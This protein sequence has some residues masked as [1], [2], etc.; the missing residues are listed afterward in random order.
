MI[1]IVLSSYFS[2]HCKDECLIRSRKYPV[3]PSW[4]ECLS[5]KHLS[6]TVRPLVI[7]PASIDHPYP[8]RWFRL[9]CPAPTLQQYQLHSE[10]VRTFPGVGVGGCAP[11]SVRSQL[12]KFEH[13][14]ED[15][16]LHRGVQ[17]QILYRR[18]GC[19]ETFAFQEET[20]KHN[21]RHY[22]PSV[23]VTH[24]ESLGLPLIQ[25]PKGCLSWGLPLT[26]PLAQVTMNTADL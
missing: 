25:G 3:L 23:R 8:G 7:S 26:L 2:S 20:D 9:K 5:N 19:T 10:W 18:W 1:W 14:S 16:I 4:V 13:V 11:C 17:G 22:L 21:W 15:I 12:K 24:C 6:D